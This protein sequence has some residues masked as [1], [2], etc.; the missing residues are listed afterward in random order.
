MIET[1]VLRTLPRKGTKKFKRGWIF[2]VD[3]LTSH[4]KT[5]EQ[6]DFPTLI[7]QRGINAPHLY[8]VNWRKLT[9]TYTKQWPL[10][11]YCND[12]LHLNSAITNA[13]F[14][15]CEEYCSCCKPHDGTYRIVVRCIKTLDAIKILGESKWGLRI[16][17]Q[18]F[19]FFTDNTSSIFCWKDLIGIQPDTHVSCYEFTPQRDSSNHRS[20]SITIDGERIT[21]LWQSNKVQTS[22]SPEMSSI[23]PSNPRTQ[24][25]K[26]CMMKRH[27]L[28]AGHKPRLTFV[29]ASLKLKKICELTLC[30]P[31]SPL[32]QL[33]A[34]GSDCA[35]CITKPR[36][37]VHLLQYRSSRLELIR[38]SLQ[39]P[40][41]EKIKS[42]SVIKNTQSV[43]IGTEQRTFRM[44]LGY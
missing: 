12:L 34:I 2:T 43:I 32:H 22:T 35:I 25:T 11:L 9:E 10:C 19:C 4:G 14:L 38:H 13:K 30:S 6:S 1:Y 7:I 8:H 16:L 15:V 24:L 23:E 41:H 33:K 27:Y 42:I 29:L 44:V 39:I 5:L 18:G 3:R 36:T 20:V 26:I 28:F 31:S 40:R 21:R 37:V 17:P